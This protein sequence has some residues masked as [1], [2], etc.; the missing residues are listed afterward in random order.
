MTCDAVLESDVVRDYVYCPLF[1]QEK[2]NVDG[3]HSTW[4]FGGDEPHSLQDGSY[5]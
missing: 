2:K 5:E 1:N 4:R 3:V